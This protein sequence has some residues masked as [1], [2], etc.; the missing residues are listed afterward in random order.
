MIWVGDTN[1]S[2][3]TSKMEK[4]FHFIANIGAKRVG[5]S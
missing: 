4:I 1:L 5:A 2:T 3:I